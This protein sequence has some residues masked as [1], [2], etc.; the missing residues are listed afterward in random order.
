MSNLHGYSMEYVSIYQKRTLRAT[1]PYKSV[2]MWSEDR[3]LFLVSKCRVLSGQ[4][5][6]DNISHIETVR[7]YIMVK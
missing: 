5:A 2:R 6:A 3:V 4:E 1:T 7:T